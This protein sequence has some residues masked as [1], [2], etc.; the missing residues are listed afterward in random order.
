MSCVHSNVQPREAQC[1]LRLLSRKGEGGKTAGRGAKATDDV[2]C[3]CFFLGVDGAIGRPAGR[4]ATSY[5]RWP[6]PTARSS[7]IAA[8]LS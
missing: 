8:T 5:W 2:G 7:L 3:K 4:G 1:R 6:L